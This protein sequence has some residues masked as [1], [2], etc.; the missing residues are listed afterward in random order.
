MS[1]PIKVDI[2]SDVACPWCFI[3]KRRFEAAVAEFDGE[4]E[5]VY[6][7]YELAPDT[8]EDYAGTHHDYLVSR[9]F[10]AEQI[11]AM[12]ARVSSIAESLDLHYDYAA[13]KPTRTLK[14]HE[15]L[16]FAKAH[17]RQVEMKERLMQAY[18]ERGEHVGRIDELVRMAGEVGLDEDAARAALV[19]GAY[20]AVVQED[21]SAARDIGV[22]GV[23]FFVFDMKYG[24]S[25]AQETATFLEVL[26]T[27]RSERSTPSPA[28]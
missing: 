14:A 4:V 15:L 26:G 13:N 27:V 23:P 18:F 19:S 9:G 17:G 16:H 21:I 11:A 25:G 10:P 3:G 7:S 8:P 22:Q 24:V 28:D 5:V 20:A 2:W 6:H 1:Q 12:D